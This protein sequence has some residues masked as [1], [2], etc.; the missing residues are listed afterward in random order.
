MFNVKYM[1]GEATEK[2][3]LKK[4][5]SNKLQVIYSFYSQFEIEIFKFI[6]IFSSFLYEFVLF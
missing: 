6:N 4:L 2:I 5:S 3:D 1:Y